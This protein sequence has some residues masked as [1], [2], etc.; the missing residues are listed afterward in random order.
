MD[1]DSALPIRTELHGD[2]VTR[3]MDA[4]ASGNL[5]AINSD[6]SINVSGIDASGINIR[7]LSSGTDSV[8]FAATDLDIRDLVSGTDKVGAILQGSSGTYVTVDTFGSVQVKQRPGESWNV[9]IASAASNAEINSYSATG[10]NKNQTTTHS[11]TVTGTTFLLRQVLGA[12]SAKF[13]VEVQVPSG[14]TK[15]VMFGTGATGQMVDITFANPI[16]AITGQVINVI[17][18]N[19]DNQAQN[20][21]STIIGEDLA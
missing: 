8:S 21:Y 17:L 9:Q 3:L 15:A 13:K 5:L 18:T 1:F 10:V 11:Y 20:L 4:T 6:G 2:V 19:R 16:E 14:T 12:G 7:P